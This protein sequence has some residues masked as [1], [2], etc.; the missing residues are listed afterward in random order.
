MKTKTILA[1]LLTLLPAASWSYDTVHFLPSFSVVEA[2]NP[3][4]VRSGLGR[5]YVLDEKGRLIVYH[6]NGT[7]AALPAKHAPKLSDPEGLAVASNKVYVA[8]TGNSLLRAYDRDGKFLFSLGVP[9]SRAGQF[10]D[11]SAIAIG[12][13]GRIY[14]ADRGNRKIEVFTPDGLFLFWFGKKGDLPGEWS[15]PDRIAV[16]ASDRIYVL[17]H[18]NRRLEEFDSSAHFLVAIP[19]NGQDFTVDRYGFIYGISAAQGRITEWGPDGAELG[20]FGSRGVGAGQF[21]RLR[22]IDINQNGHLVI[23]DSGKKTVNLVSVVNKFKVRPL[24]PSAATKLFPSGPDSVWNYSANPILLSQAQTYIYLQKKGV[25]NVLDSSGNVLSQF[26]EKGKKEYQTWKATGLAIDPSLGLYVS[27]APKHRIEHFVQNSTNSWKWDKNI[28]EPTGWFDG[29]SKEGRV[30]Y[31]EGLAI[32]GAGTLYIADPG[33]HRVDAYTPDGVYLFSIGP[34]LGA[35]ELEKPV[36]VA[37]DNAGFVY[38]LDRGLKKVFKCNPSGEFISAWGQEGEDP[39]KF[40]DPISLAFDGENYIYVLDHELKRVSAFSTDGRWIMDFFSGSLIGDPVSLSVDKQLLRVS[41]RSRNHILSFRIHPSLSAPLSISS[42]SKEG[43]VE[44]S[45]EPVKNSWTKDY[46]I[47]RSDKRYEDFLQIGMTDKNRFADSSAQSGQIYYY[48]LATEAKT[49]DIGSQSRAI[50]ALVGGTANRPEI[51]ISSVTLASIFPANY[52]WYLKHPIGS[53][54]ITNNSDAP[55]KDL[56]L[57]FQIKNYMDFGY[58]MRIDKLDPMSSIVIP[59]IATLNNTILNVTQETPIQAEL[60]LTYFKK[61]K[62]KTI[63][64]TEPLTVYSRNAITWQD[65]SRIANFITPNDTPIFDFERAVLHHQEKFSADSSLNSNVL[66]TM[67]LWEALGVYG[68]QYAE[69]PANSF[70]KTSTDPNF[71][72]D[73]AQFPRETLRRKSGQCDDLTTLFISMLDAANIRA[74]IIDY[75][76]HMAFM[77]DTHASSWTDAAFPKDSLVNYEGTYWV[78]VESTLIGK[79]FLDGVR[80]AAYSYNAEVKKGAVHII[81]VRKAW[82]TYEP[83][84]MPPTQWKAETPDMETVDKFVKQS[85]KSL[86][87]AAYHSIRKRLKEKISE[88]SSLIDPRLALGIWEYEAGNISAAK[89]RFKSVLAISSTSAAAYNN[90]GNIDFLK[91]K[92]RKAQQWYKKAALN[93]P[94]N[95][96]IWM[97]FLK[98]EIHLKNARKV[99][100]AARQIKEIDPSYGPAVEILVKDFQE[101][102]P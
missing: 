97:N 83:V 21:K 77:F 82:E 62:K 88:N 49:G 72:V 59:L 74:A 16:D 58:D 51:S 64:L 86:F 12:A 25:F 65:P 34:K 30:R 56:K 90:L 31:P 11:P 60:T 33:N 28:A 80:N 76:G 68:M 42:A 40:E 38:F 41:D 101:G 102:N 92:Y 7:L 23:L 46:L 45:W 85:S 54:T 55:F 52:K 26:G 37:W 47:Y 89:K 73:Y 10:D 53:A 61:N 13:D 87:H 43:I 2:K 6:K 27:D 66:T 67:R 20:H 69:N 78:P 1:A 29:L 36:S 15:R 19:F 22:S 84:T 63:S 35:F 39:G 17:D 70:E 24:H 8:D 96:D 57:T 18:S 100:E 50:K 4:A 14:V 94:G 91:R 79:P 32:N 3:I 48:R 99:S 71:P 75:P 98:T 44:L 95:P 9:G 81:D 5:Y 93:D